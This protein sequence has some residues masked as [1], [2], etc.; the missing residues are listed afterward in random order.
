MKFI[1]L[2]KLLGTSETPDHEAS[3]DKAKLPVLTGDEVAAIE[4]S[5]A[6]WANALVA[7]GTIQPA[8]AELFATADAFIA[9]SS[10]VMQLSGE[11]GHLELSETGLS[12]LELSDQSQPTALDVFRASVSGQGEV[13]PRANPVQESVAQTSG[14]TAQTAQTG[15]RFK[16]LGVPAQTKAVS[17]TTTSGTQTK[18]YIPVDLSPSGDEI[19]VLSEEEIKA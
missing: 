19:R 15:A 1:N 18:G 8:Q 11:A 6:Q 3:D 4:N 17:N 9:H 5:S 12:G 16:L 7:A 10:A 2:S 13:A 14:A